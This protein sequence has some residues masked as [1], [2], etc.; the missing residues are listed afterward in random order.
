MA[1]PFRF[2]WIRKVVTACLAP[3]PHLELLL[4]HEARLVLALVLVGLQLL[5]RLVRQAVA[6]G[7]RHVGPE[8]G[9]HIVGL[10]GL[11]GR[12]VGT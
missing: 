6:D 5:R 3:W 1:W 9:A 7:A 8:L 10:G 2:A 12:R 4:G 11:R